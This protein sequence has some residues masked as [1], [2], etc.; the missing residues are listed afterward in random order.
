MM[1]AWLVFGS[2]GRGEEEHY[3]AERDLSDHMQRPFSSAGYASLG[4]LGLIMS[5]SLSGLQECTV[6]TVFFF[7]EICDMLKLWTSVAFM[8]MAMPNRLLSWS[9]PCTTGCFHGHAQQVVFIAMYNRLLS[10]PWL[11]TTGCFQGLLCVASAHSYFFQ[12]VKKQVGVFSD[13]V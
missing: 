7:S 3:E 11:C 5:R 9:W 12:A 8:A 13:T 6:Q 2:Q 10:W 4:D 1:H